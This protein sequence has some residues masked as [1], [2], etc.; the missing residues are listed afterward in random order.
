MGKKPELLSPAGDWEKLQMAVAVRRRRGVSGRHL[1]RHALLRREFLAGGA[2][3]GGA[4]MP[5]TTASGSTS[6]STPCPAASEAEALPAH[7]E[8]LDD[9]G[10]GRADPGGSGRVHAGG[11]IRAPLRAA[12]QHP[13]VHRQLRLRPG[14]VRSGRQ[15]RGA[16]A[17][18]EPGR[19]PPRSAARA[20]PELELETFCHG[21]MCVSPTPA[22]ACCPTT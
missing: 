11:E 16:G 12:H 2:A 7:L 21:A 4:P 13:A 6:P 3:Q 10:C 5:M 9:A 18:A 22:A 17:G 20:S 14:V 15:A 19:D 1:L 8:Q